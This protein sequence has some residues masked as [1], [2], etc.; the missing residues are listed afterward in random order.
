MRTLV[1]VALV[2]LIAAGAGA[3]PLTLPQQLGSV[4]LSAQANVVF[5]G[6]GA[7]DQAGTAVAPAGD[8]NGDGR[9]D[10]VI[11]APGADDNGRQDSGTAYVVFGAASPAEID[12]ATLGG[13]GFRIDGAG[14]GDRTG[15]SVAAAGDING[16]GRADLLVGAHGADPQGRSN[17]GSAYV[18]FG[19]SSSAS[20]DLAALG[21]RGFR[22]EGARASERDGWTVA[23]AGDVN[24][25]GRAD[26][27]VGA[28]FADY[29][30]RESSGSAYVVFGTATT[31]TVDLAMLGDRGFRI[32]G[33][34]ARDFTGEAIAPAGD[35]N[36]DGRDD[37]LV[38][39]TFTDNNA[40]ESSGS[41]YI[42]LG[43]STGA[44]VDLAALGDQG[45]RIDG[46]AAGDGVGAAVAADDIDGDGRPDVLVGAPFADTNGRQGS[47]SVYVVSETGSSA[48]VDLAAHGGGVRIDGAATLDLAG[49]SVSVAGDVNGDARADAMLGAAGAEGEGRRD[50]GSA[51]VVYLSRSGPT[52]D[53]AAPTAPGFRIGGAGPEDAAGTAVAAAGDVNGDGRADV[54][55][56]AP[57]AD[58]PGGRANAGAAYVVYGF[59]TPQLAYDALVAGVGRRIGQHAPTV[60]RRTGPA[61]FT[62]SPAMP[63]GLRL[64]PATGVVTGTP[65]VY[66][67]RTAYTVTMRDLAGSARAMLTITVT[68]RKAP[69]LGLGGPTVQSVLRGRTVTVRASC[70]EPCSLRASGTI[71]ALGVGPIHVG[72]ARAKLEAP[73][74]TTVRLALSASGLRRLTALL[75]QGGR[76]SATVSV[77][78]VDRA[79][80]A[81]TAKRTIVLRS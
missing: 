38:G 43:K 70:N 24:G 80:N 77:R 17:A 30:L 7:G 47:G 21:D 53:L 18:V 59:G 79:G 31:A 64:D 27:L 52:V 29:N 76:A 61:G 63:A 55:V 32:D 81:S 57:F 9:K 74:V 12:L 41:A 26:V 40:R 3:R 37:V 28:L 69:R 11:G 13:H 35:V 10:V 36:R 54:L 33:A 49:G 62:V 19:K 66:A 60:F 16:D 46:A 5:R 78:A 1:P 34:A 45:I 56:G 73:G 71:R 58:P 50:S 2:V 75:T 20:V 8:V 44:T 4:D 42:V 65:T 6:A 39:A 22:I 68:D 72:P 15:R 23:P 14:A 51:Y 48:T 25:D 67:R